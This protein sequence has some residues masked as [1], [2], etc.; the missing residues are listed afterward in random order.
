M[1]VGLLRNSRMKMYSE[2]MLLYLPFLFH[3]TEYSNFLGS[4][5]R[6]EMSKAPCN[7]TN[8]CVQ[9]THVKFRQKLDQKSLSCT[10]I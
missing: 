3:C 2:V 1:C 7:L 5:N 8:E 4:S 9:E 10:Y 6:L